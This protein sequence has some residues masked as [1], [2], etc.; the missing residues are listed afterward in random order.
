M[1]I[2]YKNA[3]RDEEANKYLGAPFIH[4]ERPVQRLV[5][6]CPADDIFTWK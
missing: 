1:E 2:E 6:I 5:V 4:V 3:E